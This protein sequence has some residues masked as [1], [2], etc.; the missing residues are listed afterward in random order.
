MLGQAKRFCFVPART[1]DHQS[2]VLVTGNSR[3]ADQDANDITASHPIALL[4]PRLQEGSQGKARH[5]PDLLLL[6]ECSISRQAAAAA[7]QAA[8]VIAP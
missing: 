8:Q 4:Q 7:P 6:L 5:L 1:L 3:L 2:A